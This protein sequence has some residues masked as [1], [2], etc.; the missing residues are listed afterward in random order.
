VDAQGFSSTVLS[1]AQAVAFN[2]AFKHAPLDIALSATA[3]DET[4]TAFGLVGTL[5]STD[6]DPGSSFT[7]KLVAGDGDADNASFVISGD[8]LLIKAAAN[9][10]AKT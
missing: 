9:Y 10:E 8:R 5:S 7:Y 4:I 1:S 6:P 2:P 3:L